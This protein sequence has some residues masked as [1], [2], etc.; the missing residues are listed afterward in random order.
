MT[1][2]KVQI[3]LGLLLMTIGLLLILSSTIRTL[4]FMLVGFAVVS[5]DK[6]FTIWRLK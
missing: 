2:K 5:F 4:G 6:Y 3:N 1:P